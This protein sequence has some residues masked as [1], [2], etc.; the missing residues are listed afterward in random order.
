M[1]YWFKK[2]LFLARQD[3]R[4]LILTFHIYPG[5]R[6]ESPQLWKKEYS[7]EYFRLLREN[8][9][10]V[11][12]EVAAHDHWADLRYL[13]SEGLPGLA[14]LP[15]DEFFF[16]NMIVA[17]SITPNKKQNPGMISFDID[18]ASFTPWNL[19]FEFLNLPATQELT[20]EQIA[21]NKNLPW[22]HFDPRE[23]GLQDLTAKSLNDFRIFLEKEENHKT[24]LKYL[25]KKL[26][27]DPSDKEQHEQGMRIYEK[28]DLVTEKDHQTFGFICQMHRNASPEDFNYCTEMSENANF[29]ESHFLQ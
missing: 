1:Y 3:G 17:P 7:T 20:K 8:A 27:F 22:V 23:C 26:G 21:V 19:T 29:Y 10:L 9:D 14:D 11:I 13:S 5:T 16:H 15:G 2:Q 18:E 12:I 4:R 6:Y 24:A 28:K 25:I